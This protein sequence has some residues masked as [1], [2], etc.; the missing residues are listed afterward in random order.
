MHECVRKDHE[1]AR[2]FK[3]FDYYIPTQIL[4]EQLLAIL[5]FTVE[6][7]EVQKL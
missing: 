2:Q 5:C 3:C 6:E 4:E 1:F 7:A